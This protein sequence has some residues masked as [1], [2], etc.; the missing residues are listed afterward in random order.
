MPARQTFRAERDPKC[1]A[2]T[3]PSALNQKIIGKSRC[4]RLS[5]SFPEEPSANHIVTLMAMKLHLAPSLSYIIEGRVLGCTVLAT[6]PR[7]CT[8][9]TGAPTGH[10][11]SVEGKT[12]SF[13]CECSTRCLCT[14][15]LVPAVEAQYP[16]CMGHCYMSCSSIID[17]G[18]QMP[19]MVDASI[20]SVERARCR[21][22]FFTVK[23]VT[24]SSHH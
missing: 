1:D 3:S 5:S 2:I 24:R 6:H 10:R 15:C 22:I 16:F 8:R 14:E 18:L 20:C 12:R 11:W 7:R 9:S 4:G 21:L 23:A 17:D 13:A 19:H